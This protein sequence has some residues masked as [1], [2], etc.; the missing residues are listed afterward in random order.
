[1]KRI[2]YALL[3]AALCLIL[4]GAAVALAEGEMRT[5]D[6]AKGP[7]E[8]PVNPQKIVSDYYLGEFLA[9]GVKPIIGAALMLLS[10]MISRTLIAPHE[11][12]IGVTATV[13]GTPYFLY[14]LV[15]KRR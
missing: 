7:V 12:P 14:L 11:I 4:G 2:L 5:F 8:I 6:T 10:D 13:I 1:M 9:V 3:T 15:N